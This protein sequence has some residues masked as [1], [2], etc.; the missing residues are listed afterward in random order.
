MFNKFK[1]IWRL[2]YPT[3]LLFLNFRC[4]YL[5][6]FNILD[7]PNLQSVEYSWGPRSSNIPCNS[8]YIIFDIYPKWPPYAAF[9]TSQWPAKLFQAAGGNR[10]GLWLLAWINLG[11]CTC[12]L[13]LTFSLYDVAW[14]RYRDYLTC[15]LKIIS[16]GWPRFFI[17]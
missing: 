8:P 5:S 17:K 14:N 6:E 9:L 16:L 2:Y 15:Y 13:T 4:T 1:K 7:L 11:I 12:K 3:N 10:R